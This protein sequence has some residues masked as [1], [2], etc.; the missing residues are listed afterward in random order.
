MA[1]VN[2]KLLGALP[3]GCFLRSEGH[4]QPPFDRLN[5]CL[6]VGDDPEAVA[7]NRELIQQQL[8]LR[9]LVFANQH[10]G[11]H[12]CEAK[13]GTVEEC[14]GLMT[15]QPGIGLTILHADCQPVLMHDP[16]RAVVAAIHCGWRGNR[17]NILGLAVTALQQRYGCQPAH[18]RAF[19]GPS[20]G[21]DWGELRDYRT[22]LPEQLWRFQ[23]RPAHFDLWAMSRWQ[24]E[25]AG[26]AP[27]HIEVAGLCTRA[28]PDCFSYR[29]EGQTGRLAS[30]IAL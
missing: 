3:H 30:V 25:V 11:T 6:R 23:V 29:R 15:D 19:I 5:C 10:H 8:G 26:L 1:Q 20:L 13:P 9:H 16:V 27:E 14:D 2:S 18:L 22:L 7:A 21:P 12:I 4:S 28:S 24:L 17:D